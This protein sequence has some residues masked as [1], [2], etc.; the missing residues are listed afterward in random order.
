MTLRQTYERYVTTMVFI[1]G[2]LYCP[3]ALRH[4][5]DLRSFQ[6]A[7]LLVLDFNPRAAHMPSTFL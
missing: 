7:P 2:L 4:D 5:R 3:G 1:D 6:R